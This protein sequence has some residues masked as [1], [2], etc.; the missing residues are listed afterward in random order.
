MTDEVV[1]RAIRQIGPV[2]QSLLEACGIHDFKQ[3]YQVAECW[4]DIPNISSVADR[5]TATHG[6]AW[7]QKM[8]GS[9]LSKIVYSAK[10]IVENRPIQLQPISLPTASAEFYID[11]EYGDFPFCIGVKA[12]E[13]GSIRKFQRFIG[14]AH[15]AKRTVLEFKD[16]FRNV[17]DY[18]AYTWSGQDSRILGLER[19]HV[20]LYAIVNR[21]LMM[22]MKSFN[23]KDMAVYFGH[24]S[25]PLSIRDGLA[26]L[27]TFDEYRSSNSE[28]SRER[29][30]KEIE[31]YNWNDVESL[32]DIAQAIR[33][34]QVL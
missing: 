12:V 32:H 25:P 34:R 16:L 4:K 26:C 6:M 33:R 27:L 20:D 8:G 21:C 19:N 31:D 18:V 11:L 7:R 1:L 14:S 29:L 23:V 22:P 3:L 13:G 28:G 5:L 30:R 17:D 24:Q 2:R 10:S 15:D 9:Y